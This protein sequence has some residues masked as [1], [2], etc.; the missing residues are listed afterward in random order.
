MLDVPPLNAPCRLRQESL[1]KA[2]QRLKPEAERLAAAAR[3]ADPPTL[4]DWLW[5]SSVFWCACRC[6]LR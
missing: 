5:A 1:R 6:R 4:D 2:W 3:V